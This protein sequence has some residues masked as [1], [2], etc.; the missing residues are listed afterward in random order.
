MDRVLDP[1]PQ[2][3]IPHFSFNLNFGPTWVRL[4]QTT[5]GTPGKLP[6]DKILAIL[7]RPA[8]RKLAEW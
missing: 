2:H 5:N 4:L 8:N 7:G 6:T 3:W 1:H